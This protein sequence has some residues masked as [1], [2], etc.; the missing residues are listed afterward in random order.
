MSTDYRVLMEFQCFSDVYTSKLGKCLPT[1]S[2][3]TFSIF[4]GRKKSLNL[5]YS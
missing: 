5:A 1:L 2:V 3:F 4:K